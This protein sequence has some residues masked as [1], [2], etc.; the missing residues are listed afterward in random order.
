MRCA[1]AVRRNCSKRE[2]SQKIGGKLAR[3]L[4]K[5]SYCCHIT[6]FEVAEMAPVQDS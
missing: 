4:E 2:G 3:S 1:R 6:T 5:M